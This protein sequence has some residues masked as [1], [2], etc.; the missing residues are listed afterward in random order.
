[1]TSESKTKPRAAALTAVRGRKRPVPEDHRVRT[2]AAR[3]EQTRRKLMTSALAVVAHK[4]VDAPQI[5]DFIAAAGV[6]RGTFYNHFTTTHELLAAVTAELTDT[7]VSAIETTVARIPDPLHRMAC[8]CLVY[9]HMAVDYPAWG[10]F[11]LRTG[12][13]RGQLVDVYLPRDLALAKERGQA[14]FPTVRAAQDVLQGS[15]TLALESVLEGRAPREHVR[16]TLALALRGIG[17]PKAVAARLAAL[18]EEEVELPE[19]LRTLKAQ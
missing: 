12:T 10:G 11:V 8:G 6:S 16:D 1:M 18:P 13:R 4:G 17:V 19:V 9:M 3:R 14:D 2:G 7:V 15:L 5:D